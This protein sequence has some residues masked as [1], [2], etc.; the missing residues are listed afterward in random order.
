LTRRR[1]KTANQNRL[2]IYAGLFVYYVFAFTLYLVS[3]PFLLYLSIKEKYKKSIPARF[4]LFNN[5]PLDSA[6]VW[7]H[8]CSLGETKAVMPLAKRFESFGFS[9]ITQTGFDEASKSVKN[10]RFLPYEIFLPFWTRRH[11]L[12]V[13]MEAELWPF[14]FAS[15][16][17]RGAKTALINARISDKSFPKYKKFSYFYRMLFYFVDAVFAQTD[18]DKIR[19]EALGA[20]NVVVAGNI[21]QFVGGYELFDIPSDERKNFVAA[22]THDGEEEL[23]INSFADA[24]L[25]KKERLVVAPRHPERFAAVSSMLEKFAAEHS[26]SFSKFSEERSLFADI[27][28]V[29]KIGELVNVYAKSYLTVLGGAFAEIGGHNPLEPAYFGAKL[30]SG[31]HVFNQKASFEKVKNAYFCVASELVLLFANHDSLLKSEIVNLEDSI[32][33]IQKGLLGLLEG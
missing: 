4:F 32:G 21:K 26:L 13:V 18:I 3:I 16:K 2:G 31:T 29:D 14:L 22:S 24:G 7:F 19:L 12:L 15:A 1:P 9:V 6:D 10:S 30:I 25:L 28:L 17:M 27:V 23:I 11:K 20:K 8:S 5:R 33:A